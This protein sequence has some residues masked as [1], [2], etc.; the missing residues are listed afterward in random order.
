MNPQ[1]PEI[2]KRIEAQQRRNDEFNAETARANELADAR[3]EIERLKADIE[4][5]AK[6]GGSIACA[7][8]AD[9]GKDKDSRIS[10]LEADCA[11][12]GA[13]CYEANGKHGYS[14]IRF[15]DALDAINASPT[16]SAW[17]KGEQ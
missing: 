17:V 3:A 12:L 2:G 11:L 10:S 14:A 16:A 15:N 4:S 7:I 13:F 5:M 6:Q 1:L 8:A 9:M